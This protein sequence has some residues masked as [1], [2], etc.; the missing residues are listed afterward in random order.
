MNS[1]ISGL[2]IV[3][4]YVIAKATRLYVPRLANVGFLWLYVGAFVGECIALTAVAVV[5][6]SSNG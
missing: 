1:L 5:A 4:A 2:V 3:G 6:V